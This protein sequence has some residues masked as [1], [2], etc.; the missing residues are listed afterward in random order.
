[1]K[2]ETFDLSCE[3]PRN[4]QG[5]LLV[6]LYSLI[7]HAHGKSWPSAQARMVLLLSTRNRS[8]LN[9]ASHIIAIPPDIVHQVCFRGL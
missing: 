1:M 7:N 8:E 2:H 5:V 9:G 4:F 3:D 6:W